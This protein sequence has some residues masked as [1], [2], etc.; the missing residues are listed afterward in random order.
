MAP[1]ASIVTI[2]TVAF[3][4]FGMVAAKSCVAGGIYCG[5]DLLKRGDYITKINTNLRANGQGTDEYS[6][7]QS[8]WSCLE[9]G[10]IQLIAVCP[11]GCIGG[12]SDDDFCAGTPVGKRGETLEAVA[13][14]A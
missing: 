10:D 3:S 1:L 12:D 7:N 4:G 5:A 9:H 14:T 11:A 6:V 8:L 2:F 13:W